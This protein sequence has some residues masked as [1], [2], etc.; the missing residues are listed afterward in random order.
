MKFNDLAWAA[1]CFYYRS[2]GDK[3]YCAAMKD[4][5]FLSRMRCMPQALSVKEFEEKAIDGFINMENYDLL[6]S[7]RLTEQIL[8]TIVD[9]QLEIFTLMGMSLLE[10]NLNDR[11]LTE[12]ITMT[13]AELRAY[14]LWITGASK[15]AHLLNDRL[16]PLLSPSLARHFNIS[17]DKA[18]IRNWLFRVQNDL[19]EATA[20]FHAQGMQGSLEHFLSSK[21]GYSAEGC[22][23]SL[24]KFADEYYWL[25]YSDCL[26]VPPRWAPGLNQPSSS[27]G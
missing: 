22:K 23:K 13:Y 12:A 5:D 4:S 18:S 2:A 25:K 19:Q 6:V 27:R 9:L 24:V 15:I 10:C 7:H 8:K 11:R 3:R 20:D 14:G 21:L 17:D 26:S 1:V 16:F